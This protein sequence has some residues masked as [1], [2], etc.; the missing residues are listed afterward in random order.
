MGSSES[1]EPGGCQKLEKG[2]PFVRKAFDIVGEKQTEAHW[3]VN[4]RTWTDD[5][6][7]S[8]FGLRNI[9]HAL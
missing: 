2:F 4:A 9:K 1:R 6:Y 3:F 5:I 7:I 8:E